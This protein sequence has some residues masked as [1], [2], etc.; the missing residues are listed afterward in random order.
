MFIPW[1]DYNFF[2]NTQVSYY[3]TEIY[4]FQMQEDE[5][6]SEQQ[7]F[8]CFFNALLEKILEGSYILK[9]H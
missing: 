8:L 9:M 1:N 5:K 6:T 2:R 7:F 3:T 4:L